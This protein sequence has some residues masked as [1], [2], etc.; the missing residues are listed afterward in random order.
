MDLRVKR[1]F[2]VYLFHGI[3]ILWG[4]YKLA[5]IHS[6]GGRFSW[7]VVTLLASISLW[8]VLRK[9]NYFELV[10]NKLIIHKDYFRTQS[11]DIDQIEKID[12][13]PGPFK[14]SRI[15]MRDKS[16]VKFNEDYLD[17]KDLKEFM[18]KLNIPIE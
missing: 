1:P 6:A 4:I 14:Y 8:S 12:I 2:T 5:T 13:E 17:N 16:E 18:G 15:I 11:I 10:D 3:W 9:Q 7:T